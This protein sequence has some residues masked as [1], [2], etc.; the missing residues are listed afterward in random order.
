MDR[1]NVRRIC[2]ELPPEGEGGARVS[3]PARLLPRILVA[4]GT[5]VGCRPTTMMHGIPNFA[6]VTPGVWR[7]GQP[8]TDADWSYLRSLGIAH[9]VKLNFPSEGSDEGAV[10]A[11]LTVHTL[12]LQPEGDRDLFD[13]IAATFVGP[14][15]AVVLEAQRVIAAGGGVL[16]H[17][18]HGQDRTGYIVGRYRVQQQGWAK[19]L[20][21]REMLS[22]GFHPELHGLHEAWEQ[23]RP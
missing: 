3:G 10:R 7:S 15:R 8:T 22:Y 12:S 14:D 19:E 17:C 18:T 20:A 16:V 6:Q 5:L 21:Y 9:V 13:D 4:L 11:G 2:G 1:P 23:F